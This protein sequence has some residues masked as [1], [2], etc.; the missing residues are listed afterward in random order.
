MTVKQWNGTDSELLAL[1]VAVENHC[2]CEEGGKGK[3][4]DAHAMLTNQTVLDHM[5][6]VYRSR[7]SYVER[8]FEGAA[9]A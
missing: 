7:Q 5:V 3:T 9:A 2:S 1:R 8:E 6:F 4:C